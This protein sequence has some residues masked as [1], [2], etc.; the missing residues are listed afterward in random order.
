MK[1]LLFGSKHFTC[2]L[3]ALSVFVFSPEVRAD[4][5]LKGSLVSEAVEYVRHRAEEILY[6]KPDNDKRLFRVQFGK[7]AAKTFLANREM[8]TRRGT[9]VKVRASLIKT[10]KTE[11]RA[12]TPAQFQIDSLAVEPNQSSLTAFASGESPIG[13]RRIAAVV[14][15]VKVGATTYASSV[16]P[17]YLQ[18]L[19]F[20]GTPDLNGFFQEVSYGLFNI[21][22]DVLGPVTVTSASSNCENYAAWGQA[23]E[24]QMA[25]Q[26][27]TLSNYDHVIYYLPYYGDL[28]CSWS[29]RASLPGAQV[30][31][32]SSNLAAVAH[33]LGHNFGL[34]HAG[35]DPEN[36][37][38]LND[39]YGDNSCAM[40][41][42]P[43]TTHYNAPHAM[44][45][46]WLY[47]QG[48]QVVEL[49]S[50]GTYE[51]DIAPL[52]LTPAAA[53]KPQLIK[54]FGPIADLPYYVSF[55][56]EIGNHSNLSANGVSPD[57]VY[58]HRYAGG[59]DYSYLIKTLSVGGTLYDKYLGA[60][61]TVTS[62][63]GNTAHIKVEIGDGDYDHDGIAN[64]ADPNDDNDSVPDINDCAPY[65]KTKWRN[66]AYR[67]IDSDGVR[68][69][70][71]LGH[72]ACFGTSPP[73]RYTLN[74]NGPDNCPGKYNP[75]QSDVD[76]DGIGDSCDNLVPSLAGD[77]NLSGCVDQEDY[78]YWRRTFGQTPPPG[79]GA[80]ANQNGVVDAA[81][82]TV[83]RH[84]LGS[85]LCV[86]LP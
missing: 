25:A 63:S 40:G 5:E 35:T 51:Q 2:L 50:L 13:T 12:V 61:M 10:S 1:R 54:V 75:N 73:I 68:E 21:T 71:D 36:D 80:D 34:H 53:G 82:Y 9:R 62:I 45:L 52:E 60:R 8:Y 43:Y 55:R 31:M 46:G 22:G 42:P 78:N 64:S 33:E 3:L 85:G 65:D 7:L 27:V 26:G 70:A 20:G 29:G 59:T 23:A 44:Q 76:G 16:T 32:A 28:G 58:I 18:V 19:L 74:A 39:E 4:T 41:V 79:A 48:S 84:L 69:S 66:L 6:F 77:F 86:I 11:K 57:K 30:Y 24:Q 15:N 38:A 67:D 17:S 47:A 49:S 56:R 72:P 14:V 83:W 37:G 81:D